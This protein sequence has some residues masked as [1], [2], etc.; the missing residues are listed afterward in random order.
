MGLH[1]SVTEQFPEELTKTLPSQTF[2]STYMKNAHRPFTS[3]ESLLDSNHSHLSVCSIGPIKDQSRSNPARTTEELRA[4]AK[5][6]ELNRS[7]RSESSILMDSISDIKSYTNSSEHLIQRRPVHASMDS[8]C[9]QESALMQQFLSMRR[10]AVRSRCTNTTSGSGTSS[11]S[12]DDA[13][14]QQ[15]LS[16]EEV[17]LAREHALRQMQAFR[18]MQ[19]QRQQEAQARSFRPVVQSNSV[20]SNG[21]STGSSKTNSSGYILNDC[22]MNNGHIF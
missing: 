5:L 2:R 22:V 19:L 21:N 11:L 15:N 17:R 10:G 3:A 18:L 6:A 13:D 20:T 7:D 12:S 14:E 9:A 1:N 8:G 16:L 4:A